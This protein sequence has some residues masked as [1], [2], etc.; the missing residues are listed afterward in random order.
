MIA[1]KPTS[2]GMAMNA[3]RI[4]MIGGNADVMSDVWRIVWNDYDLDLADTGEE[5]IV[6]VRQDGPDLI[7]LDP[8]LPDMSGLEVMRRL[9][10]EG[11]K[12]PVLVVSD[13]SGVE[14]MS[15]GFGFGAGGYLATPFRDEA[16]VDA[17]HDVAGLPRT[18]AHMIIDIGGLRLNLASRKVTVDGQPAHLSGSEF[19]I[20]ELLVRRRGEV[21]TKEAMLEHLY[22]RVDAPEITIIDVFVC[23][24]RKILK[25]TSKDRRNFIETSWGK[26]YRLIEPEPDRG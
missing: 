7:I 9:R 15:R 16:L 5:G 2:K 21:V 6:L 22:G 19:S 18:P 24:M 25:A 10:A 4:F 8:R 12:A 14:E 11:I 1:D 3:M 23:H 26:G 17:M 13:P 20:L